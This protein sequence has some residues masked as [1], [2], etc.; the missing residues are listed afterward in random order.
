MSEPAIREG[1]DH[2]T[3]ALQGAI[4]R[5]YG[6]LLGARQPVVAGENDE[7]AWRPRRARL[8]GMLLREDVL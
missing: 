1:C 3:C 5:M 7:H 8:A 6:H 4:D 2:L